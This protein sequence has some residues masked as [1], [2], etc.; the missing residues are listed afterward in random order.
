MGMTAT[1][2]GCGAPLPV[3]GSTNNI[4][5]TFCGANFKV[6]LSETAPKFNRQ[7]YTT[8][9]SQPAP[10]KAEDYFGSTPEAPQ[11]QQQAQQSYSAPQPTSWRESIQSQLP[12]QL[13]NRVAT[14]GKRALW[15][16]L[17]ITILMIGA[18]CFCFYTLLN[19]IF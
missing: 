11:P 1:C 7:P 4:T 14:W 15:T 18:C 12:P 13:G 2:P 9:E 3:A 10:Q 5:C 17:I 19:W 6:D 8:A 16:G